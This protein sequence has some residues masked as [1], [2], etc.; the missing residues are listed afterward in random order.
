MSS[1]NWA[2]MLSSA[3]CSSSFLFGCSGN[4][5]S[6][7]NLVDWRSAE[8]KKKRRKNTVCASKTLPKN[9]FYIISFCQ[10]LNQ[11]AKCPEHCAWRT[12]TLSSRTR[13]RSSTLARTCTACWGKLQLLP[14]YSN[15]SNA[16][17][18]QPFS[19]I[20]SSKSPNRIDFKGELPLTN[21]QIGVVC[22]SKI[23]HADE[24]FDQKKLLENFY[25][26]PKSGKYG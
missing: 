3:Q 15:S 7:I 11:P 6:R 17:K 1:I 25:Q 8:K 10:I 22:M 14:F 2:S 16:N 12:S 23:K 24:T 26:L 18:T 13:R 19:T 4:S 20:Q 9:P 21:L 5:N